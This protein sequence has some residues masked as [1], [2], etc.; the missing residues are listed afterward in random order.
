M[1]DEHKM[2]L[3]YFV[4]PLHLKI[5]CTV[6]HMSY[7]ICSVLLMVQEEPSYVKFPTGFM[8]CLGLQLL[9]TAME[10]VTVMYKCKPTTPN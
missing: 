6:L 10:I 1:K 2:H 8:R 5:H 7:C 4:G 9:K 3:N